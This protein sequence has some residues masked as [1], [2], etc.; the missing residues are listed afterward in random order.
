ME[1]EEYPEDWIDKLKYATA[2]C[3]AELDEESSIA[4]LYVL[5]GIK[6]EQ[7]IDIVKKVYDDRIPMKIHN[8]TRTVTL[9]F[10][11]YEKL[12]MARYKEQELYDEIQQIKERIIELQKDPIDRLSKDNSEI[13]RILYKI[14]RENQEHL[15]GK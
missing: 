6:D 10:E 9:T 7:L 13:Y 2:V 14:H 11:E 3:E 4:S 15:H 1:N 12:S 5:D 8:D